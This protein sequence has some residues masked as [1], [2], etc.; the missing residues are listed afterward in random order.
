MI[1]TLTNT[2][3]GFSL[4]SRLGKDMTFEGLCD[5]ARAPRELAS[6]LESTKQGTKAAKTAHWASKHGDWEMR[7]VDP[8]MAKATASL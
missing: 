4:E 8:A 2:K 5:K 6:K 7:V 3:T 1:V